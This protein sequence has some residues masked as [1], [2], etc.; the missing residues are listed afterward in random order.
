MNGIRVKCPG[1]KYYEWKGQHH[2]EGKSGQWRTGLQGTLREGGSGMNAI[3]VL[4]ILIISL[5]TNAAI[6]RDRAKI[7]KENN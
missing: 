4:K 5:E 2:D 3:E 1:E 6:L 7:L